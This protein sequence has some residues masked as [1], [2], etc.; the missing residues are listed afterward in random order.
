[1]KSALALL[2]AKG[3]PVLFYTFIGEDKQTLVI[4]DK[5]QTLEEILNRL[6]ANT[7]RH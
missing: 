4:A 5:V 6:T 1:M 3:E 7:L 2:N